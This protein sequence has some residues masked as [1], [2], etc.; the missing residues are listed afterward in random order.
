MPR[1]LV[2]IDSPSVRGDFRTTHVDL[3]SAR[4]D[5]G[6]PR[7]CPTRACGTL[8]RTRGE[9]P[10]VRHKCRRHRQ[11]SPRLATVA[12]SIGHAR[13]SPAHTRGDRPRIRGFP[14]RAGGSRSG[15]Q[16]GSSETSFPRARRSRASAWRIRRSADSPRTAS[17]GLGKPAGGGIPSPGGHS[18]RARTQCDAARDHGPRVASLFP[19]PNSRFTRWT[20][21]FP[22]ADTRRGPAALLLLV[23]CTL[24]MDAE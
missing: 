9:S 19:P 16:F 23:T 24:K 22:P 14:P 3:R 18:P 15:G 21:P 10:P 7:P 6:S 1:F 8:R 17:G 2:R 20:R 4:G 12:P 13:S 11:V 5:P